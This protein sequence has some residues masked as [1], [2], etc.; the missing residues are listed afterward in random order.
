MYEY[1]LELEQRQRKAIELTSELE[2]INQDIA[3]LRL[4]KE[5]LE[6]DLIS[7]IGHEMEGSKAYDIGDR[8][9]TLKTDMIYALNKKAYVHGDI[10]I[11]PEFDP[12][13]QKITFEVNKK[14]FNEYEK[15]APLEIRE[16]LCDLV[17]KRPS[18]PNVSIKTRI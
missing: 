10:Y 8:C 5:R 1:Q 12:V 9:V 4:E 17:E 2:I 14:L 13:I 15:T 3:R 7:V 18:K 11:P 6:S 16:L